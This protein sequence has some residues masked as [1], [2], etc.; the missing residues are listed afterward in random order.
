MDPT[1]TRFEEY[2]E[3]SI[4]GQMATHVV[5]LVGNGLV[6][7]GSRCSFE[8]DGRDGA[9]ED[10]LN[11]AALASQSL[12]PQLS[13]VEMIWSKRTLRDFGRKNAATQASRQ[14]I[15]TP[16]GQRFGSFRQY[17]RSRPNQC[18]LCQPRTSCIP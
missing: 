1:R 13:D 6:D 7:L 17:T 18:R 11:N 14:A 5:L 8:R 3:D 10:T 4:V 9:C 2:K 15:G 12:G 16:R